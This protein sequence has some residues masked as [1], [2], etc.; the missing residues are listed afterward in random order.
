MF[1]L[2]ALPERHYLNSTLSPAKKTIK[3]ISFKMSFIYVIKPA[4]SVRI[5][6]ILVELVEK[7][8]KKKKKERT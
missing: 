5:G 7:K 8:Q 1:S 2:I 6:R 3:R 4:C